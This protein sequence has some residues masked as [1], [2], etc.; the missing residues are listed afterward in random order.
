MNIGQGNY[1]IPTFDQAAPGLAGFEKGMELFQGV[2]KN[3]YLPQTLK[4]K[5]LA[6]QLQNQRNQAYAQLS[7]QMAQAELM[8]KQAVPKLT[9]AQAYA[10]TQGG[11]QHGAEA[12][13]KE[14]ILNSMQNS[15]GKNNP[16]TSV[17]STPPQMG[18]PTSAGSNP[19]NMSRHNVMALQQSQN[20]G[21]G[22]QQNQYISPQQMNNHPSPNN[23]SDENINYHHGLIPP[24]GMTNV[25]GASAYMSAGDQAK[26]NLYQNNENIERQLDRQDSER[27]S[28]TLSNAVQGN[29][30]VS[31]LRKRGDELGFFESG[32]FLGRGT[33]VT[34]AAQEFDSRL[35]QLVQS[36]AENFQRGTHIT[37]ATRISASLAK[38]NREFL[39]EARNASLSFIQAM[40]NRMLDLSQMDQYLIQHG[41][42]KKTREKL[43]SDYNSNRPYYN[44]D[45]Q[46]RNSSMEHTW[47]DFT[48]GPA[49]QAAMMGIDY[50]PPNQKVL[51]KSLLTQK[52]IQENARNMGISPAKYKSV[53]YK[54]GKI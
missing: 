24:G 29:N 2:T 6:Q 16:T 15:L 52:D 45:I 39:P 36:T 22:Q 51:E 25:P 41:V 48:S 46:G 50:V 34:K 3:A 44:S 38:P 40:N 49:I 18:A 23:S 10:T 11:R 1:P 35:Q 37:D 54:K 9:E 19:N 13:I 20:P 53:F 43:K 14:L 33:A 30:I 32:P 47:H 21:E 5:L 17:L 42:D 28:H 31:D 4:A 12:G 7:P 26:L 27:A 8:Q